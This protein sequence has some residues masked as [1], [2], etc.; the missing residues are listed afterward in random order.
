M[1]T[2]YFIV[3]YDFRHIISLWSQLIYF[4]VVCLYLT[5]QIYNKLFNIQK[6]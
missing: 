3:F 4:E 6:L 1:T 5:L 2:P